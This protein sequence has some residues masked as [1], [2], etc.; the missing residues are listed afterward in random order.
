MNGLA[1]AYLGDSYYEL[2]IR[3]YLIE[4]KGLTKVNDLHKKA[5]QFTSGEAQCDI[6]NHLL[7]SNVLSEEEIMIFKKGRNAT[8]Y[9]RK[10][11]SLFEYQQATGFE[12]L[13]GFHY[14]NNNIT[15]LDELINLA[16]SW[17]ELN[18]KE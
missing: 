18:G 9:H 1:L 4:K 16:I 7:T 15:R 5:V 13:I 14:L 17:R 11:L 8:S 2:L 6:I 12:S 3:T 10:N